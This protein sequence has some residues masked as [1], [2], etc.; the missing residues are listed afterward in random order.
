MRPAESSNPAAVFVELFILPFRTYTPR[1][2]Q[3]YTER[4]EKITD[5]S[6]GA[7]MRFLFA[8]DACHQIRVTDKSWEGK[9]VFTES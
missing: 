4:Q 8:F 1:S 3:S 7:I 5:M 9:F 2:Y 6:Y